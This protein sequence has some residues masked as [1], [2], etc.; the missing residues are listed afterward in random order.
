MVFPGM[1]DHVSTQSAA[2]GAYTAEQLTAAMLEPLADVSAKAGAMERNAPLFFGEGANPIL[3]GWDHIEAQ[4][5][6]LE[7][8]H[9]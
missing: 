6:E 4:P 5:V 2:A 9:D 1:E 3:F 8:H 7:P